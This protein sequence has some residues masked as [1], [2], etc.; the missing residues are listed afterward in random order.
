MQGNYFGKP[1]HCFH[2]LPSIAPILLYLFLISLQSFSVI[3]PSSLLRSN[4]ILVSS[5]DPIAICKYRLNSAVDERFPTLPQYWR[6][7]TEPPAELGLQ[8][9]T[10]QKPETS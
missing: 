3:Y 4:H 6:E 7:L 2:K 8:A 9:R 5:Q 10:V 1:R